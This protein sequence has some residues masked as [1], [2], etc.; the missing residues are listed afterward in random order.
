MSGVPHAVHTADLIG[1]LDP[2]CPDCVDLM[3]QAPQVKLARKLTDTRVAV[4][5]LAADVAQY[6]DA[7]AGCGH[8][9]ADIKAGATV[10]SSYVNAPAEPLPDDCPGLAV[11]RAFQNVFQGVR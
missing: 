3:A 4:L 10:P 5:N 7:T 2:A 8:S 11:Y 9:A 1:T 6:R